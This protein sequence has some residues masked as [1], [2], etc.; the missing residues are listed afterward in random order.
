VTFKKHPR[1]RGH[2][3]LTRSIDGEKISGVGLIR[4]NALGAAFGGSSRGVGYYEEA[5][6]IDPIRGVFV[7]GKRVRDGGMPDHGLATIEGDDDDPW[8]GVHEASRQEFGDG[9]TVTVVK[10]AEHRY[11]LTWEWS[12]GTTVRGIGLARRGRLW[13]AWGEGDVALAVYALSKG[14]KHLEG[15]WARPGVEGL[16]FERLAR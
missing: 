13:V 15:D 12:D 14:G 9:F 6:G 10:V 11:D 5:S 16:G 1:S 3:A 2:L 4:G 7:E 8:A